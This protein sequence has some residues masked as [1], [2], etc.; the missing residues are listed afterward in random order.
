M[1]QQNFGLFNQIFQQNPILVVFLIVWTL[2]WKGWALW[3]AGRRND[4][5]WFIVI[6]I[7]NTIGILEILYIFIFSQRKKEQCGSDLIQNKENKTET[8]SQLNQPLD[9][10]K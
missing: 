5:I 8:N 1:W 7:L 3:R 2:A 9:Q 6:L 4:L 10:A